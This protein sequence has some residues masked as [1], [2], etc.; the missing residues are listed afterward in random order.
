[1]EPSGLP[2]LGFIG[3]GV[4]ATALSH[5]FEDAG[6]PVA[7]VHGRTAQGAERLA[8]TLRGTQAAQSR[9]RVVDASDVVFVA[10][11]DDAIPTVAESVVW[12]PG[13][14]AVHCNGA[15]SLDVLAAASKAGAE[16]GV[17]HPLQSFASAEQ[18]RHLIPGSAFRIEASGEHLRNLLDGMAR[19]V[20][21]RPFSLG[22][23][24]T[25][26]H[27]SAVLASNYLVTLLSL[28]SELWPRFGATRADGLGALLPLV[29]G[30]LENI[31]RLGIPAALTGPIARG[32][33]GTVT[34]HLRALQNVAPHVVPVYKDLALQT[35]EVALAKGTIHAEQ[36]RRLEAALV[37]T[38]KGESGCV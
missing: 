3:T 23:D 15:A 8:R 28:A 16:V 5:A 27:V 9:Q 25:L 35:I 10:V 12:S 30:T 32:D 31:E 4:V 34:H 19:A 37:G 20:G 13:R 1:M 26:Y 17:F 38:A 33:A 2:R 6:Y 14:A 18:A 7:A 24:P 29:R 22:A 11:P 21:G 36:A